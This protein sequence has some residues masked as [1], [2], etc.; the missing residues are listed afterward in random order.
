MA[1]E[2]A[3]NSVDLGHGH[4]AVAA[5][6]LSRRERD[7]V[8]GYKLS[9][10]PNPLTPTL[11]P[12]GR[13]SSAVPRTQSVLSKV[14]SR[15]RTSPTRFERLTAFVFAVAITLFG[16]PA[17]LAAYPERPVTIVVPFAPSGANDVVVRAI[18]Q[19]LAEALG[20][21]IVIE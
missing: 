16:A 19:P 8:R 3:A 13:G 9:I 4:A 1:P 7:R 11:S 5:G 2:L 12:A 17:L 6:S 20:Q 14:I 18:Q 10:D 15:N 21:P